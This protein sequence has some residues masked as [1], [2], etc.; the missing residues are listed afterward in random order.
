MTQSKALTS[1]G[2]HQAT[3]KDNLDP[4]YWGSAK[5][6]GSAE[7]DLKQEL[8]DLE[9]G[10]SIV[11][12]GS[13]PG[14]ASGEMTLTLKQFDKEL[15]R[16]LAPWVSGSDTETATGEAAGSITTIVNA[17][18]TSAVATTGIASVAVGTAAN[19][20]PGKYKVVVT[21]P[22]T[23]DIYV[24]TD[25]TGQVEYQDST[26]KINAATITIPSAS[27]VEYQGIIFTGDSGII[28]MTIGDIATFEVNPISTYLLDYKIGKLGACQ[29]EFEL[30]I[31]S[32]CVGGKLV[33]TRYPRC[34][35]SASILPSHL[36]ND[37]SS[38]EATIKVLQPA[39]VAYVA[40]SKFIN[41]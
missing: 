5:I 40:E 38:M 30:T 22:A 27:T 6:L 18:G 37:W 26:L 19:L 41:R 33:I 9:G 1:F 35:G 36:E 7:A 31:V 32:E 8:I 21:A 17:K 4:T 11:P 25:V 34:V 16:F 14:R 3:F 2:I 39:T 15:L 20:S 13:A 29:R 24:D 10:S 23:I 28:G 12:W